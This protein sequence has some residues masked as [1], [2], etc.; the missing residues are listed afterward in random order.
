MTVA[1]A[2]ANA[3]STRAEY[4]QQ[5]DPICKQ[6]DQHTTNLWR[7][8]L[9]LNKKS[10]FNKKATATLGRIGTAI[11]S[12]NH[13]LR[14]ITPPPGDEA[15]IDQWLDIWDGVARRWKAAAFGYKLKLWSEVDNQLNH[16]A[17]KVKEARRVVAGFPFQACA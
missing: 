6:S 1:V 7:R 9:R 11:A 4:A 16:I 15:L 2:P 3:A 10:E 5:A 17:Q 14:L 13:S 8:F 12:A